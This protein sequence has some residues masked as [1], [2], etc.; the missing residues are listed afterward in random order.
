MIIVI[1]KH[2]FSITV[3]R[4]IDVDIYS[5][6]GHKEPISNIHTHNKYHKSSTTSANWWIPQNA[7]T[8]M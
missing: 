5:E 3:L 1:I 2:V 4:P 7:T 8:Q 6:R